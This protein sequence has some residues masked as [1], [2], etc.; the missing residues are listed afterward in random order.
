MKKSIFKLPHSSFNA[1]PPPPV[2][3]PTEQQ[4]QV[5]SNAPL[6]TGTVSYPYAQLSQIRQQ[7]LGQGL[8]SAGSGGVSLPVGT[9]SGVIGDLTQVRTVNTGEWF[10]IF[11]PINVSHR[12]GADGQTWENMDAVENGIIFPDKYIGSAQTGQAIQFEVRKKEGQ[13]ERGKVLSIG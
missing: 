1:P 7:A 3:T 9:Y 11:L 5:Q 13:D 12:L 10:L 8:Q 6:A 2:N 4:T